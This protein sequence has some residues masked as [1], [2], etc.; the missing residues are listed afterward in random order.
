VY[1]NPVVT[2]V[3]RR[4]RMIHYADQFLLGEHRIVVR[5]DDSSS[6]CPT[7]HTDTDP[8][9]AR[10]ARRPIDALEQARRRFKVPCWILS[11]DTNFDRM[12]LWLAV[13][14]HRFELCRRKALAKRVTLGSALSKHE[15][16]EV[17]AVR[18]FRDG[19]LDL[20]AGVDFQEKEVS[21]GV[22]DNVLDLY[23]KDSTKFPPPLIHRKI[24]LQ[25]LPICRKRWITARLSSLQAS[26]ASLKTPHRV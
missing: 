9:T 18:L 12:S 13:T 6:G 17:Y 1:D 5:G 2:E 25:F 21:G 20:E 3:S 24:A 4:S 8:I 16:D 22:V 10:S 23:R 14:T 11:I 26:F 15:C 19:M 7:V